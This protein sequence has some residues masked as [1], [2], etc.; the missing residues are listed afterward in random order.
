MDLH[1]LEPGAPPSGVRRPGTMRPAG[2]IDPDHTTTATL[3]DGP[4]GGATGRGVTS[5]PAG[6]AA[7]PLSLPVALDS[8]SAA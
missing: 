2:L 3:T 8:F 4:V 1:G 6:G 7:R 5:G